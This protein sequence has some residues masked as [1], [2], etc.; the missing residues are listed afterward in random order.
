MSQ[1]DVLKIDHK[2]TNR[3]DNLVETLAYKHE[4]RVV[5]DS[6]HMLKIRVDASDYVQ[7]ENDK[8]HYELQG[9]IK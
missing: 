2:L 1:Q 8:K 5:E 9:N 3:I 6:M 4:L 7:R